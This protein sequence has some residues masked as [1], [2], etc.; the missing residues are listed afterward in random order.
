MF[1]YLFSDVRERLVENSLPTA[2]RMRFTTIV[3]RRDTTS[4][5]KVQTLRG[6]IY[7]KRIRD[8]LNCQLGLTR[9]SV[10]VMF[11]EV[12]ETLRFTVAHGH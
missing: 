10:Q 4:G 9:S 7:L 12:R 8:V 11:H 1:S 6:C 5:N 2:K 3:P